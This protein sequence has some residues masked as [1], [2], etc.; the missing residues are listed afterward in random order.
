M[1][2]LHDLVQGARVSGT[3]VLVGKLYKV[4]PS[5]L[6]GTIPGALLATEHA[7]YIYIAAYI[8]IYMTRLMAWCEH[9]GASKQHAEH[10][11]I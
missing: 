4:L 9:C 2:C 8:H 5:L 1:P 10:Q 7:A 11:D 6:Q 3:G